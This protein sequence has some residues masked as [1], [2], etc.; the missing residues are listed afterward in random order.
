MDIIVSFP[1]NLGKEISQLPDHNDLIVDATQQALRK[2]WLDKQAATS[3]K[4]A[5]N[6][7]YA[8]EN[9]VKAF[10]D[11]WSDYGLNGPS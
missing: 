10:F 6:G 2:R 7:E 1:D 8:D 5:D 11:Q 3:L 9:E 4:Q